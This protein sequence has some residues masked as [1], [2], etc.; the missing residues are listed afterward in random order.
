[1]TREISADA[2]RPSDHVRP[3][4]LVAWGQACAEPASLTEALVAERHAIGGRFTAFVGIGFA[5]TLRPEH[6]DIIDIR[7]YCATGTNR[8]LAAAGVLDIL[9]S[10]YSAM[11]RQLGATVDV[12]LLQLAPTGDAGRFSFGLACDYLHPA[13]ARARTVIAEVNDCVPATRSDW[14]IG[15]DD[16]DI[17]VR[18][19]R[20][21]VFAPETPPGPLDPAIAANVADLIPDGA[22]L[23]V[24]LGGMPAAVVDALC[25]HRDLGIHSGLLNPSLVRLMTAGAVTNIHMGQADGAEAASVAGLIAGGADTFQAS[26]G[27]PAIKLA[28]TSYTH[29]QRVLGR[30]HRFTAINSAIEVDLTGQINAEVAG[31]RYVGAVGGAT[32]FLRGAAASDGGLPIIALPSS[33]ETRDGRRISRIVPR[34]SGPTSIGRADAGVIVTEYGAA[35]LRGMTDA[36]RRRALITIAHP[37]LRETLDRS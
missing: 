3:G 23:Q 30:L 17:V 28:P 20:P 36:Q 34:L 15:A 12:L 8:H 22:T 6:T 21:P 5:D 26:H 35:D 18:T 27:N 32:D 7:S 14:T 11:S 29:S 37:D 10:H 9:P 2:F 33:V 13:I 24:G 1:M 31:G 25:G 19:S 4:D 16:I